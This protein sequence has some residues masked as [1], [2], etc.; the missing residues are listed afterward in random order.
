MI[1][2]ARQGLA[3]VG[4]LAMIGLVAVAVHAP[5]PAD[6]VLAQGETIGDQ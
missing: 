3:A 6:I 4:A 5:G 2:K 1:A